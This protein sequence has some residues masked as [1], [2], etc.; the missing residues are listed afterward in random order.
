MTALARRST[1]IQYPLPTPATSSKS[2]SKTILKNSEAMV[3]G[4]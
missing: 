4:W 2:S 3:D 1:H